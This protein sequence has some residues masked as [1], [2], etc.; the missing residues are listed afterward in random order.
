MFSSSPILL[1]ASNNKYERNSIFTNNNLADALT[2][3]Q[4]NIISESKPPVPQKKFKIPPPMT[5]N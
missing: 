5:R 2:L 1:T 3:Q 4:E